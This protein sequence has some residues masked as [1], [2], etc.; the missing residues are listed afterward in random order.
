MVKHVSV[1]SACHMGPRA[2]ASG[3]VRAD[4]RLLPTLRQE[5]VSA[6]TGFA[7]DC[8]HEAAPGQQRGIFSLS[9]GCCCLVVYQRALCMRQAQ[10]L[11][12][13]IIGTGT[14]GQGIEQRGSRA[15]Y[16]C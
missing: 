5:V 9:R 1:R 7:E 15:S 12:D 11:V 14:S 3:V 10:V 6:R 16:R 2:P 4:I 13:T 8:S